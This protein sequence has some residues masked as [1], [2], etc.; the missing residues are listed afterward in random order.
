MCVVWYGAVQY[1]RIGCQ[2][3]L[4]TNREL[5]YMN[6]LGQFNYSKILST[7]HCTGAQRHWGFTSEITRG[8]RNCWINF[9]APD[10]L[11]TVFTLVNVVSVWGQCSLQEF[12]KQGF[13]C[14]GSR[15]QVAGVDAV[16][17]ME[18]CFMQVSKTPVWSHRSLLTHHHKLTA[19]QLISSYH[20]I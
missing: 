17:K 20:A 1:G 3:G 6:L 19:N 7:L 11:S 13:V 14:R 4:S 9:D 15:K 2:E 8:I 16:A 10:L 12:A 5:G 18:I